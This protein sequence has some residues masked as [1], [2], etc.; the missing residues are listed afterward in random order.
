ML[1]KLKCDRGKQC[2]DVSPSDGG[3]G[4][5]RGWNKRGAALNK[6]T[7]DIAAQ[8]KA[9]CV[10]SDAKKGLSVSQAVVLGTVGLLFMGGVLRGVSLMSEDETSC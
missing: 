8:R 2:N 1:A 9:N 6:T 4:G 7:L 10:T 3:G 5:G